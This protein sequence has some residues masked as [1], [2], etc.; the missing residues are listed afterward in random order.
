MFFNFITKVSKFLYS[1]R[2][3]SDDQVKEDGTI[4]GWSLCQIE[5]V[6]L[7][8]FTVYMAI[9]LC[10]PLVHSISNGDIMLTISVVSVACLFGLPLLPEVMRNIE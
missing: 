8:C 7:F 2:D 5:F 6:T 4:G 3:E 1:C 10:I 9:F